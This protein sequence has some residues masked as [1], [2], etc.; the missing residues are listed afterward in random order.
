MRALALLLLLAYLALASTVVVTYTIKPTG[1]V[2]T[3][4]KTREVLINNGPTPLNKSGVLIPPYSTLVFEKL[5]DNVYPPFLKVE[6]EIRYIGGEL[7]RGVLQAD[8]NTVVMLTLK[9]STLLPISVPVMISLATDGKVAVIYERLPTSI[10]QMSGST[11]YHWALVV[12]NYTEF[13]LSFRVRDFGSFG[14]V[15]LPT[16][17][18]TSSLDLNRTIAVTREQLKSL[19]TAK[20]R[21]QNL[22]DAISLYLDMVYTQTQNLTQL[23]QVFNL[24]GRA[25]GEGARALNLSTYAL[26]ALRRQIMAIGDAAGGAAATINQSRLLVDYQYLAL[27]TLANTLETQ[28]AALTSYRSATREAIK[29][30]EDT[31]GQLW[32]IRESLYAQRQAINNAIRE[33]ERAKTRISSMPVNTTVVIEALDVV[34][35]QLY[36]T[37]ES[38]DSLIDVVDSI[39]AITDS[40]VYTLEAIDKNLGEL[41]PLLNSTAISTRKNATELMENMPQILANASRNLAEISSN[42][43]KT[44]DEVNQYYSPL[45]DAANTLREVGS[46]LLQSAKELEEFRQAQLKAVPKLGALLATIYN[47]TGYV[48]TE[49]KRLELAESALVRYHYVVNVSRLELQY[50]IELPVAMKNVTL[51]TTTASLAPVETRQTPIGLSVVLAIAAAFALGMLLKKLFG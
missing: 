36:A 20:T 49:G 44:A 40:T 15:R 11:I 8:N 30:L 21:L 26:E 38:I 6:R 14:A 32:S 25:L 43:Y 23:I 10:S 27:M 24:T 51:P 19:H 45:Y 50:Y 37:R 29:G 28:A 12:E 22:T 31:R 9:I 35:R 47:Y 41:A 34:L 17:L 1:E 46:R 42:L 48:S 39:I 18:L 5:A 4:V 2:T 13:N 33:V 7:S 3:V 16:V